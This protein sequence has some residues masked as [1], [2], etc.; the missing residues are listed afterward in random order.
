MLYSIYER[1]TLLC[2]KLLWGDIMVKPVTIRLDDKL[3]KKFEHL[4]EKTEET[5]PAKLSDSKWGQYVISK[6]LE[7]VEKELEKNRRC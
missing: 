2:N 4:K 3:Y 5:T 1:H 7:I 6:G